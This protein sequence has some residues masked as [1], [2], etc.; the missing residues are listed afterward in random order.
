MRHDIYF[1]G[2]TCIVLE[3]TYI[4]HAHRFKKNILC[5]YTVILKILC[6]CLFLNDKSYNHQDS[7]VDTYISLIKITTS[8]SNLIFISIFE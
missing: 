5:H 1:Y 6:S 3:I 7:R 2:I 8:R 4:F